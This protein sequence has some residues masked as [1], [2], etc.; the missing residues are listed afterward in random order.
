MIESAAHID[1]MAA[2]TECGRICA[3]AGEAQRD[4]RECAET[5]T[6]LFSSNP[7]DP[8]L[9]STVALAN[10]FSAP[11][12]TADRLR[13]ANR[14]SLWIFALDWLID[15]AARSHDDV[16]SITRMCLEVADGAP[17]PTNDSLTRF[18]ADL[19]DQLASASAFKT[20]RPMWRHEL[21]R[22]LE[23][24]AREWDWKLTR[25]QNGETTS[26]SFEEYLANAD[27]SGF[28]FVYASHWV[29]TGDVQSGEH[30][31]ELTS[32]ARQV[33]RA[34]R[35]INDLATY[36]RDVTWG[37]LNAL[38]LGMTVTDLRQLI[39]ELVAS[40]RE[41]LGALRTGQPQLA[42]YL[43]RQLGF[44]TGFYAVADYWGSL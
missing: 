42:S 3:I 20:L 44:N 29:Y 9:F 31:D 27:N 6:D 18:L 34:L 40:C 32:A 43:E 14:A 30:I 26:P 39:A 4:L 2:V 41:R 7:F 10:A 12:L 15:Y 1:H 36:D 5:Y 35:L 21:Q 25:A 17:P 8:A 33:Q 13:V 28:C 38:M 19:V 22:T 16:A 24:M 37:D 23:A 11:W